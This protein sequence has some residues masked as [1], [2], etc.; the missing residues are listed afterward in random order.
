MSRLP[1]KLEDIIGPVITA[2]GY[3][4]VGA[5]FTKSSKNSVLVV[6]IDSEDGI[7]LED[8][9]RVS[10]QISGVLD[11]E[12]PIPGHYSLEVSSPGMDRLLFKAEHFERFAGHRARVKLYAPQD[13]RKK[14]TGELLGLEGQ[15]VLLSV[16][17]E[18][19]RLPVNAIEKARLVPEFQSAGRRH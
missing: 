5:E 13:G 14:F 7:Q 16:D 3:E 1:D 15:D 9:T 18:T 10:H 11:V 12:D 19:C 17:G 2:M 6:Y 8:C 4:F